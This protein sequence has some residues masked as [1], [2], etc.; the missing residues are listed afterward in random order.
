MLC[1]CSLSFPLLVS[2][3]RSLQGHVFCFICIQAMRGF[4]QANTVPNCPTCRTAFKKVTKTLTP[5]DIAKEDAR[6][7]VRYLLCFFM[8]TCRVLNM[9]PCTLWGAPRVC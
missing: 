8:P 1:S 2:R 3:C 5:T 9:A 7:E 6:L 4:G